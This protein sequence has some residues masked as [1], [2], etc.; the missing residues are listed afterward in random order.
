MTIKSI[1][2]SIMV[3]ATVA[4]VAFIILSMLDRKK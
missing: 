2:E 4:V 3:A 1:A